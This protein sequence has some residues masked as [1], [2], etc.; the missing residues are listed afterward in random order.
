MAAQ[1]TLF[2][3]VVLVSG[4]ESLLADRA[5]RELVDAARAEVPEAELHDV[6][7]DTLD[8][9]RLAEMTGGSL[10]A[11]TS[12]VVLRDLASLPSDLVD[13]VALL[14]QT[15]EPEC[16]LVLVHGGGAKGKGLLDKV[17]KARAR[18][19]E[20]PTPKGWELP[21]FVAAEVRR[22][23]SR[24]ENPAAEL[25]VDAVGHDLRSL[26][27]AVQQLVADADGP[28]I[29]ET[30]VRRY[31]GGRAEVTSFAVADAAFSGRTGEAMEQLRWALSTGVPPVLVSSAL[32]SG[33]RGLGKLYGLAGTG[34]RDADVG[35][36]VGVPHWKVKSMRQQLRGWDQ[37][38]LARAIARVARADAE[39]KGAATDADYALESAVLDVTRCRVGR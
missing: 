28:E 8:A 38:G 39:V 29:T 23:R 22:A 20:C 15:P 14:A 13:A 34:L 11:S 18:V 31:F 26:A 19:V 30:L 2:G 12:V 1:E 6:T 25:L 4:A 36:E 17:K 7:A 35:R 5:V 27:S 32:A 21:R 33:L 10:F 37:A 16:A 24:I 3:R 9:G